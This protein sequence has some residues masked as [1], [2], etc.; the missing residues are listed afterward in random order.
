MFLLYVSGDNFDLGLSIFVHLDINIY[1]GG[2]VKTTNNLGPKRENSI[3]WV[4][5]T[6][7]SVVL[8]HITSNVRML[9][10]KTSRSGFKSSLVDT[11]LRD[12]F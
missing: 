1:Q 6:H 12:W 10:R 5:V 4:V 2:K 11:N 7:D 9:I 3:S 8:A